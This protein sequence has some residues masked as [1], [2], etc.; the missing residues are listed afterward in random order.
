MVA[1]PPGSMKTIMMLNV[2]NR[3]GPKVPTLYHSSDSDDFTMTSRSLAMLTG[4]PTSDAELMVMAQKPEAYEAL[5]QLDHVS[6]SFAASPTVEHMWYE[7]EAYREI[8]GTYPHHT[9]VDILMKVDYEGIS[10]Y[11]YQ[12]LMNE[13]DDMAREQ[14]TAVTIVHHT[15]ESA[16]AGAPPPRGAIIGKGSQLPTLICTLWGDSQLGTLDIAVVK[17]RFGPQ[18]ATAETYFTMRAD[19]R[20]CLIEQQEHAVHDSTPSL[21]QGA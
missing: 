13:L 16:K 4:T 21:F 18:D 3:M 5:K 10:E 14:E 11:N 19:A 1:G 17:N 9:V 6:W 12:N 8:N 15:S 7:A 20:V 2:V